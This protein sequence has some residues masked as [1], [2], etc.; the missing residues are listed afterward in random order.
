MD[1]ETFEQMRCAMRRLL[2]DVVLPRERETEDTDSIPY[3]LRSRAATMGIFGHAADVCARSS[4]QL[5]MAN[6]MILARV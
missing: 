3:D 4:R 6:A 5:G 1:A 2:P